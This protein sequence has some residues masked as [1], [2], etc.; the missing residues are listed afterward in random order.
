[1]DEGLPGE[2][3][4]I[5]GVSHNFDVQVSCQYLHF[6]KSEDIWL[7][8]A[9]ERER[10]ILLITESTQHPD[11]SLVNYFLSRKNSLLREIKAAELADLIFGFNF[12]NTFVF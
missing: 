2:N 10:G 8:S 5:H 11:G 6:S 9:S 7:K 4:F 12:L 3:L 1:M